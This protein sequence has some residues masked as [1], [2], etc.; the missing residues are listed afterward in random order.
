MAFELVL[1]WIG[2]GIA[3]GCL[4]NMLRRDRLP[5]FESLSFSAVGAAMGALVGWMIALGGAGFPLLTAVVG[6]LA[7][8]WL[9][10]AYA[11][12][13]TKRKTGYG[14]FSAPH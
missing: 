10:P 14:W 11:G 3:A 4:A 7:A 12:P 8:I 6:A 5:L 2:A 1:T 13:A 9:A